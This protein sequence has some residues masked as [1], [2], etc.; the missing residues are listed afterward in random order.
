MDDETRAELIE[1]A[2]AAR[3]IDEMCKTIGWQDI[4]IPR[5]EQLKDQASKNLV[6]KT[7]VREIYRAQETIK[8]IDD[9][10]S[11]LMLKMKVGDEAKEELAKEKEK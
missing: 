5:F 3:A 2:E 1:D 8:A 7:N 4:V 6:F 9:V 11:T 10:L